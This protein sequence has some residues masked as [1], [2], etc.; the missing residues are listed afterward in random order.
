LYPADPIGEDELHA[1]LEIYLREAARYHAR[2]DERRG[3][4]GG[5]AGDRAG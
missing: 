4:G 2:H 1:V 5:G 3:K